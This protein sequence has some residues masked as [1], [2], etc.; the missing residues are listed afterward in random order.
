MDTRL[1]EYR[2][3]QLV[4]NRKYLEEYLKSNTDDRDYLNNKESIILPFLEY[5]D[6]EKISADKYSTTK[7]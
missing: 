5:F 1:R 4:Y 7:F 6:G 2:I 3:T